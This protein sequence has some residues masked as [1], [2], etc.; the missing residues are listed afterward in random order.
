MFTKDELVYYN[1]CIDFALTG[2]VYEFNITDNVYFWKNGDDATLESFTNLTIYSDD[3]NASYNID[4]FPEYIEFDPYR[5]YDEQYNY[6]QFSTVLFEN[7]SDEEFFQNS[8]VVDLSF[9]DTEL[10]RKFIHI[11]LMA[12]HHEEMENTK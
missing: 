5:M 6:F 10:L 8:T 7:G 11:S 12:R 9:M 3:G 4:I 2:N 1:K